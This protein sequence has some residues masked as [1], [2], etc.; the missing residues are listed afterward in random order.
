M[1]VRGNTYLASVSGLRPESDFCPV[2]RETRPSS[3]SSS[4]AVRL[5]LHQL[6][7]LESS[8]DIRTATYLVR[9]RLGFLATGCPG[10]HSFLSLL[11]LY[12]V[13]PWYGVIV[14]EPFQFD[15][16]AATIRVNFRQ[17]LETN[18]I[19]ELQLNCPTCKVTLLN[20]RG[21]GGSFRH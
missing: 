19:L 16:I 21:P 4:C 11:H 17:L 8:I 9:G 7:D 14:E 5:E 1:D 10:I 20:L 18:Q 15:D 13:R 2:S 6:M 3:F 12:S